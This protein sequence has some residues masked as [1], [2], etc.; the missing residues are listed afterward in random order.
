MGQVSQVVTGLEHGRVHQRGKI[1]VVARLDGI[2]GRFDGPGLGTT[3]SAVASRGCVAVAGGAY[4]AILE[5]EDELDLVV[6]NLL[7]D[8]LGGDPALGCV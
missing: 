1:G 4:L 6:G 2:Q 3:L 8:D 5:L 7:V